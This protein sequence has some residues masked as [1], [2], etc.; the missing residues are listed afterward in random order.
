MADYLEMAKHI[1]GKTILDLGCGTGRVMK[2]LESS[3]YEVE[4]V[5]NNDTALKMAKEA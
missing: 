2:A 1:E 5:D 3:G 4:G